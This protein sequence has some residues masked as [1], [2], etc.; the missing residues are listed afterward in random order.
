MGAYAE[1]VYKIFSGIAVLAIVAFIIYLNVR[2]R[3]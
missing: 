1:A 3:K 2:K